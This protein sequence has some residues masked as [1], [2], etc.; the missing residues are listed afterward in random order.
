VGA[1][2]L[3]IASRHDRVESPFANLLPMQD[4]H[5][6]LSSSGRMA[7]QSLH[8]IAFSEDCDV[9]K[10]TEDHALTFKLEGKLIGPWVIELR[11]VCTPPLERCE[12]IHLDFAAVAFI[13]AAGTELLR[14]LISRGVAIV[15]Y[16][17]FLE[18][19]M[20]ADSASNWPLPAKRI[21]SV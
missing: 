12:Q 16:S 14:E 10:I 17:S 18:E 15:H 7:R 8:L 3:D 4:L 19:L 11:N 1:I 5:A 13:D 2:D 20:R 6:S 9:L 21:P